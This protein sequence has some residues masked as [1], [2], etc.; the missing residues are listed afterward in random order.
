MRAS[1]QEAARAAVV[2]ASACSVADEATP[3]LRELLGLV[4][5]DAAARRDSGGGEACES[6]A[7]E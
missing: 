7:D 1:C 6:C 5:V 4:D 3:A 2:F